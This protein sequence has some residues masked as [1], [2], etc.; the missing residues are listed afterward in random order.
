S[1]ARAG[2]CRRSPRFG[3]R[4]WPAPS[5]LRLDGRTCGGLRLR[6]ARQPVAVHRERRGPPAAVRAGCGGG[7]EV[8]EQ[9]GRALRQ[10]ALLELAQRR[11]RRGGEVA[12]GERGVAGLLPAQEPADIAPVLLEQRGALV[13][14]MTLEEQVQA[15]ALLHEEIRTR[16]G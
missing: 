8:G 3:A 1:G 2:C 16:L 12:A 14:R 4:S 6:D 9:R 5:G 7:R 10:R 13:L 11:R 15:A